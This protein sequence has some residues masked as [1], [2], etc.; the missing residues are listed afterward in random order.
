[1]FKTKALLGITVIALLGCGGSER[2]D[3]DTTAAPQ[4]QAASEDPMEALG[5]VSEEVLKR[6]VLTLADDSFEG[7][8]P[9]TPGGKKT[10]EYLVSEMERLGLEPIGDSFEHPVTLV[11]RTLDPSRSSARFNYSDTLSDPLEYGPEAVYWTKRDDPELSIEDSEVIFVGHGVVAPEYGWD[12]YAGLDATGKTVVMLINDPGFRQQGED[13]GGNAMTYYGRWTYKFE[14]AARQGAAAAIII[15]QAAPAAYGWGV[16][17]GSW[18]GPQLNLPRNPNDTAP[19]MLEGWITEEQ[20]EQ[21]FEQAGMDLEGMEEQATMAGFTPVPIGEITFSA[22]L[23]Q[24]LEETESANVA[25]VLPGTD[26]PDEYV[27]YTAHWDHLGVDEAMQANGKDGI[28]NGAV[29][30]ATGTGGILAIAETYADAGYRP[31]RSQIFLAVTAEE[32]GLLG[33]KAFAENPPVP[34]SSIVGG[35]NIDA[36]LPTGPANDLTVV[37]YG[38]SELEDIL[39]EVAGR[40]GKVLRPDPTPERGYFYRSDHV[41][42]AKRGVPM[43]Y[44]D[45]GVDLIEGGEEAGNA[46]GDAYTSGPYHNVTDEVD[47]PSTWRWDGM[48]E[49]LT[50]LRDTGLE[51][52]N[53]EGYPNWYEGNEFR[54]IRDEQMAASGK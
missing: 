37:G 40:K 26:R 50:I 20:A 38:S 51:I 46:A 29:D 53:T 47:H 12:D 8:A 42:F 21:L 44:V 19:V 18:S 6:H 28:Y 22:N 54:A 7:R 45:N 1:M 15:H 36:I 23:T 27:I 32:S 9:G 31:S 41:E 14:E 5:P 3:A 13:F 24:S 11:S 2:T 10:R 39:A 33:S 25:G 35:I 52:A 4:A 49:L 43:L 17:E 48:T 30:N 16:V 34:L